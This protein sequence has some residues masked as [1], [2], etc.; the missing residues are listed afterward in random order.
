MSTTSTTLP[1]GFI[2][3][4]VDASGRVSIAVHDH[5]ALVTFDRADKRNALDGE[6]FAAIAAAGA[7]LKE[8]NEVRVVVLH[9]DGASF[10][11]GLDFSGFASMMGDG[12]SMAGDPNSPGRLTESGL[13]HLGQQVC[14]VWQELEVPVI[15]AMHGHALGG[16]LQIA[17]GADIRIAHPDTQLSVREVHWG[18]IPDMTGT[19]ILDRLVRPDVARELT[20]TARVLDAREGASIGLVT[21][22]SESPLEDAL[23]MAR[24]IAA[25]NPHAV[26]AAKRLLSTSFVEGAG[27]QF[28]AERTEVSALI[29]T[30]N[31]IEVIQANLEKRTPVLND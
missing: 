9:G 17:L 20:Y 18:I 2:G 16:G 25:R 6:Q 19:H 3:E 1:D 27:A 11:A 26:R 29:G 7:R 8:M 4:S 23:G 30:T 21:K 15:A 14:W 24:E 5:V 31:Q 13:T 22:L 28:A 10:C 12:P